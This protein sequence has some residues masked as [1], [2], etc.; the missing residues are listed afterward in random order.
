MAG[1]IT[2]QLSK[3]RIS[4][5]GFAPEDTRKMTRYSLAD[6]MAENETTMDYHVRTLTPEDKP[7][8][9]AFLRRFFFR[10]EPLNHTIGLIPEGENSTC[11]ELEEY[12]MSSLDQNLSLMAVSS[13]GAIVGVQ[14]NGI[15]EPAEKEDEPDYIKSCENA[16]FKKILKLLH[17]VDQKVDIMNRYPDKKIMDIR[18]I[19]VDSNWRG[20]GVAAVLF[21]KTIEIGR[22]LGYNLIRT[23]CSSHFTAR[24]C[25]RLAFEE[26]YALKYADYVDESGKPVFTPAAPH[27]AMTTYV[28]KL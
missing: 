28:R 23:D 7:K 14:L 22:E 20:Q 15:T 27:A 6:A 2:N 4:G 25:K 5:V 3:T 26:I 21:E 1:L 16:K 8:V 19:S 9:L 17:H 10:D 18:I 11:L 13:G 12:S 24:L